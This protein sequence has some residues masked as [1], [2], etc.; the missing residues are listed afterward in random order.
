M[1]GTFN[2]CFRLHGSLPVSKIRELQAT[3]KKQLQAL[4]T[5]SAE[6]TPEIVQKIKFEITNEYCGKFNQLLDNPATGPVYLKQKEIARIVQEGLQYWDGRRFRLICFCIMSNHVHLMLDSCEDQLFI[7]LKSIKTFTARAAN[8]VLD[9]TGQSFWQ[10]ESYDNL[11]R[12]PHEL[13]VKA[14]YI[15]N[16]PVNAG[17]VNHWKDWDFTYLNPDFHWIL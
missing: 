14:R 13:A 12:N 2:I 15:L 7:I 11:V 3:R 8:K 6:L 5:I 1:D 17:L 9:R 4:K 10:K 16:N